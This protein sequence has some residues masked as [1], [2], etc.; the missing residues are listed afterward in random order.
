[1]KKRIALL[2]TVLFLVAQYSTAQITAEQAIKEMR[3]GINLGNTLEPPDEGSWNNGPAEEFYFELYKN[4]GFATVRIPVRWDEHTSKTSPYTID[5]NWMKRVEQVVD[6]GLSRG[7]YI[8]VNAHHEE[9]LKKNYTG[10][11]VRYDSIWSQISRT[12]KNR[13]EKLLFE[14]LNEPNGLTQT[15]IDDFNSKVLSII[16]KDNP[17]RIVIYSGKAW[18]NSPDLLAAKIP[19]TQDSYLMAYYH[20]YDPWTFAGEAKGTWG[21]EADVSAMENKMIEVE[22]WSNNNKIPVLIGEFGAI[23]KCDYNSRMRY[24]AHYTELAL[25]HHFAFCA[26][27]D[28]GDFEILQ[29]KMKTWNEIKDIL[30]YTSDSTP[31]NIYINTVSDSLLQ[32][33]WHS[34]AVSIKKYIIEKKTLNTNFK[35]IAELNANSATMFIDSSANIGELNI[36]RIKEVVGQ[37]TLISY[38]QS[39]TVNKRI[40]YHNEPTNIPGTIETED[41]DIG[42]EMNSYHDLEPENKGGAYRVSEGVDIEEGAD[43]GFHVGYVEE[44]EWMEYTVNVQEKNSYQIKAKLASKEGGGILQIIAGE[45]KLELVAPKTGDWQ[46]FESVNGTIELDSGQQIIRLYIKS[47]PAFNIDKIEAEVSTQIPLVSDNRFRIFPNP[48]SNQLHLQTKIIP[49]QIYVRDGFGRVLKKI[50]PTA[51]PMNINTNTL[52]SGYYFLCVSAKGEMTVMPFIKI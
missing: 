43:G 6:W 27:D 18:A 10:Q 8:I 51:N 34:R 9:S 42:G 3:R 17:T 28:G 40:P 16:R 44:G 11:A 39:G 21:S 23:N 22:S 7:L 36:Y 52:H 38:P 50:K 46:K 47:L 15:Q 32:L 35:P 2:I 45:N 12:F 19:D 29:R 20:S 31:E 1:M 26:W 4:V 37:D 49:E 25:K 41:F 24:Y 48:V 33:S 14:I 30:I 5:A 13:S